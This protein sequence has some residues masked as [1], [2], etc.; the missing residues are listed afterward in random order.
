MTFEEDVVNVARCGDV[1]R[2]GFAGTWRTKNNAN[3]FFTKELE[4]SP[5]ALGFLRSGRQMKNAQ[6]HFTN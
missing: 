3:S 5:V 1:G 6:R 4:I 2:P